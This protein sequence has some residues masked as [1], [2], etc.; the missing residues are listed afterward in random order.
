M[1]FVVADAK[2]GRSRVLIDPPAH[3]GYSSSRARRGDR[4]SDSL[5][6]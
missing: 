3:T 1:A 5:E 6:V 4:G 2:M